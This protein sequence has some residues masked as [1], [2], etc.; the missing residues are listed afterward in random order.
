MNMT[1][2]IAASKGVNFDGKELYIVTTSLG[3]IVWVPKSQ[4][5]PSAET[6]TFEPK[7]AG[8][9]YM[10]KAGEEKV[11]TKD[12]NQ[13]V[14]CGKMNKVDN[15]IRLFTELHKMGITPAISM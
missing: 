6:V 9:K 1:E 8:D 12:A 5:D 13:F 4:F 3:N 15:T 14:G 2:P 10:N 11:L 7:K